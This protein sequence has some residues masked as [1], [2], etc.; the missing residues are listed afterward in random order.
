[1]GGP[2]D[3]VATLRNGVIAE[4]GDAGAIATAITEII[5]RPE[6]WDTFSN[7]GRNNILAY[8]WPSHVL[9][10]LRVVEMRRAGEYPLAAA[11]RTGGSPG[12]GGMAGPAGGA[13]AGPS[14]ATP[15]GGGGGGPP[16]CHGSPSYHLRTS[17]SLS[18][19]DLN[20]LSQATGNQGGV[21]PGLGAALNDLVADRA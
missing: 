20:Q 2:V 7:N 6:L 9:S 18:Y 3:I 19:D 21:L 1:H 15:C 16:G 10:Y 14:P 8:S 12:A 17:Y 11:S 13:A 5:T 4:P